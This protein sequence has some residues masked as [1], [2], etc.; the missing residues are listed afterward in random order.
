MILLLFIV[1][2][3]LLTTGFFVALEVSE[4]FRNTVLERLNGKQTSSEHTSPTEIPGP[5]EA[6]SENNQ[7]TVMTVVPTEEPVRIV[8]GMSAAELEKEAALANASDL[9]GFTAL[10]EQNN[11]K[12]YLTFTNGSYKISYKYENEPSI[13]SKTVLNEVLISNGTETETFYWDYY[14]V[15][16]SLYC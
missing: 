15:K 12:Q 2:L 14:F 6:V 8:Q 3:L 4:G 10:V 9:R 5:T 13:Y 11:G 7:E 16:M 1:L